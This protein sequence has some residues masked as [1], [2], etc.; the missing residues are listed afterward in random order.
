MKHMERLEKRKKERET[1]EWE[2]AR[3][4]DR[5]K[6]RQTERKSERGRERDGGI[7]NE[8]EGEKGQQCLVT[9]HLRA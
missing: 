3:Q 2:I 9:F 6:E 1:R 4:R 8:K 7:K 5:E